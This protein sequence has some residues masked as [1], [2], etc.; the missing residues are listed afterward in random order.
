MNEET[1]KQ[2]A[3]DAADG[4]KRRE[5]PACG[6]KLPQPPATANSS[7]R[8]IVRP[9]RPEEAVPGQAVWYA[10]TCACPAACG[11]GQGPRPAPS[12]LKAIPSTPARRLCARG[13]ASLSIYTT[14][15]ATPPANREASLVDWDAGEVIR[16]LERQPIRQGDPPAGSHLGQPHGPGGLERLARAFQ[17]CAR[18][19]MTSH[20]CSRLLKP[21]ASPTAAA[22]CRPI[23]LRKPR[24][25]FPSTP[26]SS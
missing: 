13:Q 14:P 9:R 20:P 5:L 6:R 25:S 2:A 8:K 15:S 1:R 21:T 7:P 22:L 12:N 4:I 26:T 24:L 11:V 18:S 16:A 19:F 17:P 23:I 10:T 3:E